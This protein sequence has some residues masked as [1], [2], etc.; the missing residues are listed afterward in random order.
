[1]GTNKTTDQER[2]QQNHTLRTNTLEANTSQQ[3][4]RTGTYQR[5]AHRTA[6]LL[7]KRSQ[8]A[9]TDPF[10]ACNIEMRN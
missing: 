3:D 2:E 9:Q 10:P 7:F 1:M 8:N 6:F 5:L 4:R